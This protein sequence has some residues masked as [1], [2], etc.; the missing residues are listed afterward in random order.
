MFLLCL[1]RYLLHSIALIRTYLKFSEL[2]CVGVEG[3]TQEAVL[4]AF[5]VTFV[6]STCT[7]AWE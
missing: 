4:E 3:S 1:L 7:T 6:S 2:N 5:C